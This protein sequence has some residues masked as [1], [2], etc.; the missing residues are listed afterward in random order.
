[1]GM[2]P[3]PSSGGMAG[4]IVVSSPVEYYAA[5]EKNWV[6]PGAEMGEFHRH[7][8]AVPYSPW[9]SPEHHTTKAVQENH[10]RHRYIRQ[11]PTKPKPQ[12]TS[13]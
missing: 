10:R 6:L 13:Y 5:M 12:T 9:Y 4:K 7:N 3:R 11:I 2:A 1:M 8:I